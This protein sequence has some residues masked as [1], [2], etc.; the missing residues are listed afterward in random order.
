LSRFVA[1][2]RGVGFGMVEAVAAARL[3]G[4]LE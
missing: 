3:V 1:R 4:G 2:F